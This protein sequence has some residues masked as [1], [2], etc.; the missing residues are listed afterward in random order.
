MTAT[1]SDSR[2]A[3]A[4]ANGIDIHY[5]EAG[6]R[7]QSD[8]V[9]LHGALVSTNPL[10]DDTPF[11]YGGY[12]AELSRSWHVVAPDLRGYGRTRHVGT[13][14]VSMSLLADDVAALLDVLGLDR[15]AVIGFS[16]GGMVATIMAIRHPGSVRALVNDAGCDVFDPESKSFQMLPVMFGGRADAEEADPEVVE[17]TFSADPDMSMFLSLIKADHDSAG[18]PDYWHTMLRHFFESA[19]RWPGYGFA[20]L[21]TIDAPV[22]ILGGDRDDLSPVEDCVRA[23]R[24]LR[25]GQ[26]CILPDTGHVITAAK[27]SAIAEFVG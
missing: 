1:S 10:W 8:L 15:P 5:V 3:T 27:V 19:Q 9:V 24:H 11:S 4:H 6:S 23:Y 25:D 7:D 2:T 18:G 14:R 26:L 22:L 12:L 21:A 13:D 20:D 16:L 17:R